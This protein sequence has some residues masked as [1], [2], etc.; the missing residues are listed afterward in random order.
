MKTKIYS[1]C[2]YFYIIPTAP[3][4]EFSLKAYILDGYPIVNPVTY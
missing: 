3:Y 4:L 2:V 1:L